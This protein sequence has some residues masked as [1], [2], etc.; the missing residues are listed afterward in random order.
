M[1]GGLSAFLGYRLVK[2]PRRWFRETPPAAKAAEDVTFPSRDGT[3]LR[4]WFLRSEGSPDTLVLCHGWQMSRVETLDLAHDLQQRG[5]NVFLFDF[6]ACGQSDGRYTTVGLMEV[7]DLLGAVE[8][9]EARPEV[10][11]G[12]LGV[13]GFSMGA[14]VALM[15]AAQCRR[16]QAV[17]ADSSFASLEWVIDQARWG[18]RLVPQVLFKS[19]S[20]RVG[21]RLAGVRPSDVRPVDAVGQ[22]APRPVLFIHGLR[23]CLVSHRQSQHLYSAASGPKELWLVEESGHCMARFARPAEYLDRVDHFFRSAFAGADAG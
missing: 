15:V 4:G 13:L 22:I 12:H 8:H 3:A 16:L 20:I 2:P 7:G 1:A 23:D 17:V 10:R 18:L 9:L 11:S 6:R 5:Y 21:Q 19:I 14:A